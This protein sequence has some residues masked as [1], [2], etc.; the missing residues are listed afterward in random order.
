MICTLSVCMKC[1]VD[2]ARSVLGALRGSNRDSHYFKF[3][4]P[5]AYRQI[6]KPI[7]L[8]PSKATLI[9]CDTSLT[10]TFNSSPTFAY[11][12]RAFSCPLVQKTK[13]A[14][15]DVSFASWVCLQ[16]QLQNT[17]SN[18]SCIQTVSCRNPVSTE[19]RDNEL[20]IGTETGVE[21]HPCAQQV[22]E[23]AMGGFRLVLI[24]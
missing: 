4:I 23:A 14:G 5:A 8:L 21:K 17:L 6:I 16:L 13:H 18:Y 24:N 19:M 20:N 15:R 2:R 3:L 12:R 22:L 10:I 1:V 9:G 7:L 11:L